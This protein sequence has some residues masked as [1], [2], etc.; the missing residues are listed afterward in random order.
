MLYDPQPKSSI[1]F[2]PRSFSACLQRSKLRRKKSRARNPVSSS[3]AMKLQ[4]ISLLGIPV[5]K[6]SSHLRTRSNANS[7][8]CLP[9]LTRGTQPLC[10]TRV[11]EL[12][13]L[14]N[15]KSK[16]LNSE[17]FSPLQSP[18]LKEYQRWA[19]SHDKYM[20]I[21]VIRKPPHTGTGKGQSVGNKAS[22]LPIS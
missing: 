7:N 14:P 15:Q 12:H 2:H 17:K 9:E 10:E 6:Y 21:C 1:G 22:G 3:I 8:Y 19:P 4:N 16:K 13:G 18:L 5:F 20:V 11:I